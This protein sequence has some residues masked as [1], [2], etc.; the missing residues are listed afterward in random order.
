VAD[1]IS[2]LGSGS[3]SPDAAWSTAV[4]ALGTLTQTQTQQ[5][6]LDDT[7]QATASQARSS[8]ESVSLDQENMNLVAYQHAY[9]GSA[10]VLTTLDAVLD[11]LINHTGLVGLG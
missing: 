9:E 1:A 6:A 4:V 8:Q 3:G 5:A 11:H 7:A 2:R 10:R